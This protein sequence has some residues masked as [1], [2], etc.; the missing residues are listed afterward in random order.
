MRPD[1][2]LP[3]SDRAQAHTLEAAIAALLL[4]TSVGIALQMTAVTPLSASTSSQHLEN[5]L[6]KTSKGIL[7][8]NAETGGLK[9]AVLYWNDTAD[10]FY[11][12]T[13][14]KYYTEDPPKNISLGESLNRTLDKRNVAYN[15]NIVY[16]NE[17][18][19]QRRQRMI[20]RGEPSEHAVR[21]SHSVTIV[22]TDKLRNS[23]GTL[24]ATTVTD[25]ANDPDKSLYLLD[26]TNSTTGVYN[27]VRVEVIAWRI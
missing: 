5:Q 24:S 2:P 12:T 4:L 22:D 9:E 16:Q 3:R 27:H 1:R 20:Y 15:V 8:S 14:E 17:R 19:F 7:A 18:G 13:G 11:N 26:S 23:D 6:E 10:S 25:A 21:A